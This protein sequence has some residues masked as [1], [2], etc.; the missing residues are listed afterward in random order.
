MITAADR[1][2]FSAVTLEP[3]TVH[4]GDET[5]LL[6]VVLNSTFTEDGCEFLSTPQR[7]LPVL[8]F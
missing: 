4:P 8:C 5:M 3:T 2:T 6:H 7:E 1:I